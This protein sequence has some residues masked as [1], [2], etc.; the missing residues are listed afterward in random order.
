MWV[1]V[2]RRLGLL[3]RILPLPP[4]FPSQHPVRFFVPDDQIILFVPDQAAAK[5]G[6]EHS[7]QRHIGGLAAMLDVG[8]GWFAAFD[9]G[10]EILPDQLD[11]LGVRLVE[12]GGLG[13]DLL[14]GIMGVKCPTLLPAHVEGTLRAEE[15]HAHVLARLVGAVVAQGMLPGGGESLK[16]IHRQL[17]LRHV[18]GTR[19]IR[20]AGRA[21]DAAG[22]FLFRPPEDLVEPM[23]CPIAEQAI[24]EGSVLPPATGMDVFAVM[25]FFRRAAIE[26]PIEAVGRELL[27]VGLHVGAPTIIDECP[28]LGNLADLAGAQEVHA[29]DIVRRVTAVEV[30]DTGA[31]GI[32][33][34]PLDGRTFLHGMPDGLFQEQVCPALHRLNGNEGVPMVGRGVDD[35]LRAG[36]A[37]AFPVVLEMLGPIRAKLPHL[38]IGLFDLG[39]VHIAEGHHLHFPGAD[40]LPQDVHA[41]PARTDERDGIFACFLTDEEGLRRERQA[42]Q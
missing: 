25:D 12:L 21:E 33:C 23:W 2:G 4:I 28:H 20:E 5:A 14:F 41:P 27:R 18:T 31:L 26:I 38:G 17:A 11:V 34:N 13:N 32:P 19:H 9:G 8:V 7:Q 39:L 36:A 29:A 30:H 42:C 37:Q 1:E 22:R 16:L 6:G 3:P 10:Q 15:L 24:G 35:D 40:G